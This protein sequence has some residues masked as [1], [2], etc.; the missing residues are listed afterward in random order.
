MSEQNENL[1]AQEEQTAE[2]KKARW[3]HPR[4]EDGS[5]KLRSITDIV[6]DLSKPLPDSAISQREGARGKML[7]YITW[8]TASKIM[9]YYAP[10]WSYRIIRNDFVVTETDGLERIECTTVVEV[11][12]PCLEGVVTR[13]G[14]AVE[15]NVPATDYKTKLKSGGWKTVYGGIAEI[16]EQA[17]FR[18]ALTKFGLARYLYEKED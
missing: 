2:P 10:G 8:M 6:A 18:R 17:A 13:S 9:D 14:Q 1:Q 12:V 15:F 3:V 7:D 11:S 5:V 16:A 4:N